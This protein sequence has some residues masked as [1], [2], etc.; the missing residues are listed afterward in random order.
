MDDEKAYIPIFSKCIIPLH[1][2][3]NICNYCTFN[4]SFSFLDLKLKYIQLENNKIERD[5]VRNI[6]I[7]EFS[8]GGLLK[9]IKE[10]YLH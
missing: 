2:M 7:R 9:R 8:L 3:E 10:L 6:F 1:R 4:S 5:D